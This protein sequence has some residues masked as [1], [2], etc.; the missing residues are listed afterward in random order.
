[1][2][3][4]PIHS[5][6]GDRRPQPGGAT[7]WAAGFGPAGRG[8]PATLRW[9]SGHRQ[10]AVNRA[11]AGAGAAGRRRATPRRRGGTTM[12]WIKTVIVR[13]GEVGLLY[14]EGRYVRTLVPGRYRLL[15]LPWISEDLVRVDM[16]RRPLA[17]Q[18]QEMLTAD[19][20]SVRLNVAVEYRVVDAPLAL[21]SVEQY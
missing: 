5:K 13:E 4:K 11:P 21:H 17:I 18:G 20:I 1:M 10:S 14:R 3:C 9:P 6:R 8:Y 19:A 12:L 2:G 15:S 16:R 7:R